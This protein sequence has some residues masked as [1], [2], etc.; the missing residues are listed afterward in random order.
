[1]AGVVFDVGG[2]AVSTDRDPRFPKGGWTTIPLFL[3][4]SLPPGILWHELVGHGLTGVFLG[5]R[6][7]HVEILGVVLYPDLSWNG[8]DGS[9]GKATVYGV[10][11]TTGQWLVSLNGSMS[12]WLV[13]L[14]S[15]LLLWIRP[16]GPVCRTILVVLGLW[17]IDLLTYTL[18]SFGLRRSIFWGGTYSEPYEAAV[19]L[20][21]PGPLFQ[22][23][24]VV[25]S[26][27]LATAAYMACRQRSDRRR[28]GPS[29]DKNSSWSRDQAA[30]NPERS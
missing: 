9:Y 13:S 29:D 4:M 8:W 19:S 7:T 15:V 26:A 17:W 25:S 11:S 16:W 18:P 2:N 6:I 30:R 20:G 14:I 22:S 27:V 3:V 28:A 5:G 24:V 10:T 1:M 23:F 21:V 12:T